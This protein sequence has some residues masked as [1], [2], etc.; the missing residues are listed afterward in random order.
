MSPCGSKI[1]QAE[2]GGSTAREPRAVL[3]PEPSGVHGSKVTR[4]RRADS[5][6][7]RE[8]QDAKGR[9]SLVIGPRGGTPM[10]VY[11]RIRRS[12]ETIAVADSIEQ[13]RTI[14]K[15]SRPGTFQIVEVREDP[16]T[17]SHLKA[18]N[19]GWMTHPDDGPV[20]LDPQ[21]CTSQEIFP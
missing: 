17:R 11:Y 3:R 9:H 7:I 12:G 6:A 1:H 13:A 16:Q 21:P 14:V 10:N 18:R 2:R 4:A 5:S 19:W 15:E 20:I 8:T